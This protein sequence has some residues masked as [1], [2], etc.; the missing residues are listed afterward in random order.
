[1]TDQ[2]SWLEDKWVLLKLWVNLISVY[3]VLISNHLQPNGCLK[4]G[5][6]GE[7]CACTKRLKV[8]S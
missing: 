6:S 1:M 4:W 8:D 3:R 2:E 5:V 7:S